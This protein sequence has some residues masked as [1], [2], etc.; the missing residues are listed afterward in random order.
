M[1][2]PNVYQGKEGEW[3]FLPRSRLII[4]ALEKLD[5]YKFQG[6]WSTRSGEKRR[7]TDT[8]KSLRN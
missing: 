4:E 3:T 1:N 7:A 8:V 5:V 6:D 2:K